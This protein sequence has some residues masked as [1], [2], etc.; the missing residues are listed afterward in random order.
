MN[1]YQE[2]IADGLSITTE[3]AQSIQ[4]FIS[5]WF[6]DFCWNSST[7]LQIIRTAKEAQTM[8]ADPRYAELLGA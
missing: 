5:N 8:M 3:E 2:I 6:D 4:N 7:K 1:L